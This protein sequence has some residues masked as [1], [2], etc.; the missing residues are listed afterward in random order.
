MADNHY[1][2]TLVRCNDRLTSMTDKLHRHMAGVS[3]VSTQAAVLL[4]CR[5][6]GSMRSLSDTGKLLDGKIDMVRKQNQEIERRARGSRFVGE[7]RERCLGL[8]GSIDKFKAVLLERCNSHC[9]I[10]SRYSQ[11]NFER[12]NSMIKVKTNLAQIQNDRKPYHLNLQDQSLSQIIPSKDLIVGLAEP[13]TDFKKTTP[14]ADTKL[15]KNTSIS[16]EIV[17]TKLRKKKKANLPSQVAMIFTKNIKS[18]TNKPIGA[19]TIDTITQFNTDR[20]LPWPSTFGKM[21]DIKA[22]SVS[23]SEMK[24]NSNRAVS[25]RSANLMT[26]GGKRKQLNN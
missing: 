20:R 6:A 2:S 7:Y 14:K 5:L 12:K 24:I 1:E 23:D 3:N 4:R 16:K 9:K 18:N 11:I 19:P 22:Q 8:V 26:F 15:K 10:D 25:N 21:T 13:N 17:T